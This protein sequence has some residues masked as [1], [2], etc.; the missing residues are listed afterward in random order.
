LMGKP[1]DFFELVKNRPG[2]DL[3]YSVNSSKVRQLSWA[4]KH[5]LEEYLPR[6]L[7][8]CEVGRLPYRVKKPLLVRAL[9]KITG[10]K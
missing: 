3:R 6:Y 1:D 8:L 5:T 10:K 2:Q 7:E 9:R 4:P